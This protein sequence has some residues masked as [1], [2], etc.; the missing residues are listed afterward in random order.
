MKNIVSIFI[1]LFSTLSF[2]NET[3]EAKFKETY[4]SS[5]HLYVNGVDQADEFWFDEYINFEQNLNELHRTNLVMLPRYTDEHLIKEMKLQR[6]ARNIACPATPLITVFTGGITAA[7]V[8]IHGIGNL[9]DYVI[10]TDLAS[11]MNYEPGKLIGRGIESGAKNCYAV[12]RSY[13][14]HE[15]EAIHRGLLK[16]DEQEN[17]HLSLAEIEFGIQQDNT[18]VDINDDSRSLVVDS[19]SSDRKNP[20]TPQSSISR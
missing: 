15:R 18:I 3:P 1:V 6:L 20:V 17:A 5:E 19:Q 13:K 16:K 11:P 8:G 9:I 10:G 2:A 7:T 14:L 4:G 12:H